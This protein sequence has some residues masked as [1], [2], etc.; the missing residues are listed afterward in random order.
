[1][2]TIK[3]KDLKVGNYIAL[4]RKPWFMSAFYRGEDKRTIDDI[5]HKQINDDL[6]NLKKPTNKRTTTHDAHYLKRRIK[7]CKSV[8]YYKVTSVKKL[9]HLYRPWQ[10][11]EEFKLKWITDVCE[12]YKEVM[13]K[14]GRR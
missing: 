6:A 3:R 9:T 10:T 11:K 4:G 12:N 13:A 7:L 8:C 5:R 2:T 14:G 1:M